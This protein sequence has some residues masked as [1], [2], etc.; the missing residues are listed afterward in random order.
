[1]RLPLVLSLAAVGL[2]AF[3]VISISTLV[4]GLLVLGPIVVGFVIVAL[5]FLG[6]VSLGM[7]GV[8]CILFCFRGPGSRRAAASPGAAYQP[9]GPAA[10]VHQ[11]AGPPAWDHRAYDWRRYAH[12]R[13]RYGQGR[14][15]GRRRRHGFSWVWLS[16]G[17]VAACLIVRAN[18]SHVRTALDQHHFKVVKQPVRLNQHAHRPPPRHVPEPP[19]PPDNVEAPLPV[20]PDVPGPAPSAGPVTVTSRSTAATSSSTITSTSTGD[21]ENPKWTVQGSSGERNDAKEQALLKAQ[22]RITYY[23]ER[24][25]PPVLWSPDLAYIEKHLLKGRPE[26]SIVN[27]EGYGPAPQVSINVEITP[28]AYRDILREY[29]AQTMNQ[30]LLLV[31]AI[32][33]GLVAL[34]AVVAG[35]LRLEELTKGYYTWWLRLGALGF[36]ALTG[37]GLLLYFA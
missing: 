13:S 28:D 27:I 15:Y 25:K 32:V 7:L 37:G 1:M 9:G 5:I 34:F 21:A 6:L 11:A 19:E 33:G 2:V 30:R 36:L 24:Q 20:L 16:L 4:V 31:S 10:T 17:I 8:R 22:E 12:D 35:Y 26:E 18:Y 14:G 3:K 29:R 23:L